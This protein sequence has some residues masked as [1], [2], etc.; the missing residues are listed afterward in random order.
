MP[1]PRRGNDGRKAG[2]GCDF[3]FCIR[4]VFERI[5]RSPELHTKVFDD[6]RLAKI[7]RFPYAV[8]YRIDNDQTTVVAVY[9]SHRDPRE[10]QGRN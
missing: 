9:H 3:L 1:T 8:I 4:E 2:L 5:L 7:R 6:L 10:W